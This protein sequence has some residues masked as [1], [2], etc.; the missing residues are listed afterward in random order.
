M[1]EKIA[2]NQLRLNPVNSTTRTTLCYSRLELVCSF[3][4]RANSVIVCN[5]DDVSA[6][7]AGL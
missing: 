7:S 1:V 6:K 3:R 4:W 2:L 5:A